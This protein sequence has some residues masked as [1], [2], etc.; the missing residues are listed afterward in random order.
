M[1]PG[2]GT[3]GQSSVA[4]GETGGLETG[5]PESFTNCD[6]IDFGDFPRTASQSSQQR[7]VQHAGALQAIIEQGLKR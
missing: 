3:E 4:G 5:G 1:S 7:Y 6:T 2:S